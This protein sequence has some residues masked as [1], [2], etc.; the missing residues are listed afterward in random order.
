MSKKNTSTHGLCMSEINEASLVYANALNAD[1]STYMKN[2]IASLS[3]IKRKGLVL[4]PYTYF[5]YNGFDVDL[6]NEMIPHS[7]DG[8]EAI[9]LYSGS[10]ESRERIALNYKAVLDTYSPRWMKARIVIGLIGITMAQDESDKEDLSAH[11]AAYIFRRGAGGKPSTLNYFD[12]AGWTGDEIYWY[13]IRGTFPVTDANAKAN[14]SIFE[15]GGGVSQSEYTYIGQNIFCHSWA[16][17]FWYQLLDQGLSMSEVE[18]MAG[19]GSLKNQKNLIRIKTFIYRILIDKL[20]LKFLSESD[21]KL[22]DNCFM[23]IYLNKQSATRS[24]L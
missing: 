13:A 10:E 19:T 22:F 20:K 15:S 6:R 23:G 12:S 24:I 21:K 18:Q 4:A 16:L 1:L 9:E 8:E 5:D 14:V 2:F 3:P 17:W 11:Y 7:Y